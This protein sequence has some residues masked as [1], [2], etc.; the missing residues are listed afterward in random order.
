M[1][2]KRVTYWKI[3][4]AYK[5]ICQQSALLLFKSHLSF[6]M[7]LG[8]NA[9]DVLTV[10]ESF[11]KRTS[12]HQSTK[13]SKIELISFTTNATDETPTGFLSHQAILNVRC[14]RNSIEE[15]VTFFIK[16]LPSGASDKHSSYIEDFGAFEKEVYLYMHVIPQLQHLA[17]VEFAPVCYLTKGS[18]N[19]VFENLITSGYSLA[20]CTLGTGLLDMK[21]LI[22]S[23]DTLAALHASSIIYE[24]K[25]QQ[26]LAERYPTG[27]VENA[28]PSVNAS[29]SL[30]RKW[31]QN[32]I[33]V[34][35]EMV[36]AVP[37]YRT[38]SKEIV[39]N[40]S[41]V[42]ME[43][44]EFCQQ[45]K[46]FRNVFSHGDLWA[47]NIM[48][49]YASFN[50]GC[51]RDDLLPVE[52][53][54]VD[55]Q[56][57]RYA[58]PALDV[59]TL[60]ANTTDRSFRDEHLVKLL[61]MYHCHLG[62]ELKNHD[63]DICVEYPRHEFDDSCRYYQLAGLIESALFGHLILLPSDVTSN[64][65]NTA[66]GFEQFTDDE[67]R[68]GMCMKA[69]HTDAFYRERL[70]GILREIVDLYVLPLL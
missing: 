69:F 6:N 11:F 56:L 50:D 37:E 17:C 4:V 31:V 9:K 42:I 30:R 62:S 68:I 59:L 54:L 65:V 34:L 60:I 55:F 47:N 63:L 32:S 14:R 16:S 48:F 57:A 45:S 3:S 1:L 19:L 2:G 23:L 39:Q 24:R 46:E 43:I 26:S 36:K 58:P 35:C 41:N 5:D 52:S 70:S 25:F 44:F 22:V 12:A 61:D 53:K 10:C 49:R 64:I 51:R 20:T 13:K 8:M 21:H 27:I 38:Q 66:D 67:S 40:L 28:Y 7:N 29:M 18:T 15:N 33:S